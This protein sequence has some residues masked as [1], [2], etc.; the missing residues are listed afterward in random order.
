MR[1]QLRNLVEDGIDPEFVEEFKDSPYLTSYVFNCKKFEVDYLDKELLESFKLTTTEQPRARGG[2]E[3]A[4]EVLVKL[5]KEPG[6]LRH[7]NEYVINPLT[8]TLEIITDYYSKELMSIEGELLHLA[9]KG[10]DFSTIKEL[11]RRRRVTIKQAVRLV[12]HEEGLETYFS[13]IPDKDELCEV[14]NGIPTSRRIP[15]FEMVTTLAKC[16]YVEI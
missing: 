5:S 4:M 8:I 1:V 12:Y 9:S 14:L 13:L 2:L 11:V 3:Y 10:K 7:Y 15:D 6:G 16:C